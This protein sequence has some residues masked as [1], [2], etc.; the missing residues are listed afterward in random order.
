MPVQQ[1]MV[2]TPA[3]VR[4]DTSRHFKS[5]QVFVTDSG[6]IA[7]EYIPLAGGQLGER[8]HNG[9]VFSVVWQ[10]KISIGQSME[11]SPL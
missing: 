2:R 6:V 10:S 1:K 7:R 3:G 8:F 5:V 4:P 11:T 9:D